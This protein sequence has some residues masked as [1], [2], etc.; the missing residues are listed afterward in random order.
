MSFFKNNKIKVSKIT[1]G[2]DKNIF[3]KQKI[4]K[5]YFF[6]KYKINPNNKLIFFVEEFI[7]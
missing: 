4:N 3:F 5:N 1:R 7:N 2:I 6:N